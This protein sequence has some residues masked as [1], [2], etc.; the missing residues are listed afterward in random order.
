[1]Y[2]VP[3]QKDS[4]SLL[5]S[6][7]TTTSLLYLVLQSKLVNPGRLHLTLTFTLTN[8]Y[9]HKDP[10][11][12]FFSD[13]HLSCWQSITSAEQDLCYPPCEVE[14]NQTDQHHA[15][16]THRRHLPGHINIHFMASSKDN[17]SSPT[18]SN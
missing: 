1:M 16:H 8:G 5:P 17:T 10:Q 9:K 4:V 11:S 12:C 6:A 13:S 7:P 2:L 15:S 14:M 3:L 18:C